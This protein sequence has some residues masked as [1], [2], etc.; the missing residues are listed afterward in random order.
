VLD[1]VVAT[2]RRTSSST[3]RPSRRWRVE[4]RATA[5]ACESARLPIPSPTRLRCRTRRSSASARSRWTAPG[6]TSPL[7]SRAGPRRRGGNRRRGRHLTRGGERIVRGLRD[8][9]DP[10]RCFD[11]GLDQVDDR[12]RLRCE[13]RV[14]GVELDRG[15]WLEPLL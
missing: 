7:T 3:T 1:L 11:R 10:R 8:R 13:W 14:A 5:R 15:L 12:A 6:W 4:G 9:S 2:C